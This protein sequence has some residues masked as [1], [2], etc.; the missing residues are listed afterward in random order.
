MSHMLECGGWFG[1][2][3]H[4]GRA[5]DGEGGCADLSVLFFIGFLELS[6]GRGMSSCVSG[7]DVQG[8]VGSGEVYCSADKKWGW[9]EEGRGGGRLE[10]SA[11]YEECHGRIFPGDI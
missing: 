8:R 4:W 7:Y 10:G 3:L 1:R 2:G 6:L 5:R 9:V 11:R